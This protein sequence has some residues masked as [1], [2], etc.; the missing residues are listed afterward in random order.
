MD[1]HAL[2]LNFVDAAIVLAIGCFTTYALPM[3]KAKIGQENLTL[4]SMWAKKFVACAEMIADK[5]KSGAEKREIVMTQLKKKADDLKLNLS[6]D[7]IRTLLEDAVKAMK[8]SQKE[9]V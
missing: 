7:E 9:E 5:P 1:I 2:L 6:E 3:I 8:D 4:I